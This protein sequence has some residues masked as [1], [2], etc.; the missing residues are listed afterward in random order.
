M[1]I[2]LVSGR[3]QAISIEQPSVSLANPGV[4]GLVDQGGAA[5]EEFE[6][7]WGQGRATVL[8]LV[9]FFFFF[10]FFF[11]F[12]SLFSVFVCLFICLFICLFVCYYGVLGLV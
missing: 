8:R 3:T 10:F 2:T 7:H 9:I 1:T 5:K 4:L 11:F 6:L 12:L